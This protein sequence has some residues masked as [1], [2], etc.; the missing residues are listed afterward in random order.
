MLQL[1]V[2]SQQACQGISMYA[3]AASPDAKAADTLIA[4]GVMVDMLPDLKWKTRKSGV[5]VHD[6]RAVPM[7]K[8][9]MQQI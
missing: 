2:P 5:L 3:L 9:Q 7:K 8:R 6:L 1:R 4:Q